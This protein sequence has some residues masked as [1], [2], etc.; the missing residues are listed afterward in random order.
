MPSNEGSLVFSTSTRSALNIAHAVIPWRLFFVFV[1]V[2]TE[3]VDY[4]LILGE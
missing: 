3:E 1:F 2:R 4:L